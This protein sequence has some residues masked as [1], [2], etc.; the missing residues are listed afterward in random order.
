MLPLLAANSTCLGT[1]FGCYTPPASG[2]GIFLSY[3]D[4]AIFGTVGFVIGFVLSVVIILIRR[5]YGIMTLV[6][7]PLGLTYKV[8][9]YR[10]RKSNVKEFRFNEQTHSIDLN[11]TAWTDINNRPVLVYLDKVVPPVNVENTNKRLKKALKALQPIK[12]EARARSNASSDAFDLLFAQK[13]FE[14]F[15]TAARRVQKTQKST[16]A[17]MAVIAV[18]LAV[19]GYF[20]GSAFP[21]FHVAA[22]SLVITYSTATTSTSSTISGGNPFG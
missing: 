12:I 17:F 7:A 18:M 3:G 21:A 16:L 8:M 6:L 22:V 1:L 5:S 9:D 20:V 13:V 10:K 4:I 2:A 11:E 15:A 19:L 14:T